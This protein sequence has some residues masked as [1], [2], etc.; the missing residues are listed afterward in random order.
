MTIVL[1]TQKNAP[2]VALK[3]LYS[4]AKAGTFTAARFPMCVLFLKTTGGRG[5]Y[6]H[7]N[8]AQ[9][10]TALGL[11]R[12]LKVKFEEGNAAPRGGAIGDYL[13]FSAAAFFDAI[14]KEL[15]A[16]GLTLKDMEA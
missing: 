7:I 13:V 10:Y 12:L 15:K 5:R 2:S 4:A 6:T 16:R 8:D 11:L 9:H 1:F 3:A 14:A